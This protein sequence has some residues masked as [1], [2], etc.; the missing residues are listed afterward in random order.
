MIRN[1]ILG[2]HAPP[3]RDVCIVSESQDARVGYFGRQQGLGPRSRGCRTLPR[4]LAVA[5]E[6]VDEND[7]SDWL[8]A[9]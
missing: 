7:A 2:H 4:L 8:L 6:A 1:P 3:I 9:N 5:S